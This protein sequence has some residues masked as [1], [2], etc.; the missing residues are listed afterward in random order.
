MV[1]TS[2]RQC[3]ESDDPLSDVVFEFLSDYDH[4]DILVDYK[5]AFEVREAPGRFDF[6]KDLIAFANNAGGY[7][8]IGKKDKTWELEG[9]NK[10]TSAAFSN[11]K[12]ILAQANSFIYPQIFLMDAKMFE[13]DGKKFVLVHVP[14]SDR[15]HF[16]SKDVVYE[17]S[18]KEVRWYK[19]QTFVRKVEES[20]LAT[21]DDLT[22]LVEIFFLKRRQKILDGVAQVLSGGPNPVVQVVKSGSVPSGTGVTAAG[23]NW[24]SINEAPKSLA[25]ALHVLRVLE[26]GGQEPKPA[27]LD[28]WFLWAVYRDRQAHLP[29][30]T[31]QVI[32]ILAYYSVMYGA[33]AFFWLSQLTDDS[34]K[35]VLLRAAGRASKSA[36]TTWILKYAI[37]HGD[38]FF[39]RIIKMLGSRTRGLT[40]ARLNYSIDHRSYIFGILPRSSIEDSMSSLEG[41]V[42]TVIAKQDASSATQDQSLVLDAY[43]YWELRDQVIRPE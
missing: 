34:Q 35:E 13:R 5:L 23:I 40:Q 28:K 19:S 18:G 12:S 6:L 29:N 39:K 20:V 7:F 32:E 16:L 26:D 14:S 24:S 3:L 1:I 33:P 21:G 2:V 25:D 41:K 9:T 4:E 8:F 37:L 27:Q 22:N 38:R 42:K 11:P 17:K 31:T 10:A 15:L 43:L 30:L 36:R